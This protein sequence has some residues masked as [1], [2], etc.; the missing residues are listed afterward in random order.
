MAEKNY[1]STDGNGNIILQDINGKNININDV[2]SI[3]KIFENTEPE[4]IQKLFKQ[5]DDNY[6]KFEQENKKQLQKIIAILQ[7]QISERKITVAE[8]KNI[9]T[10]T[11]SNVGGN[12]HI[13]DVIYQTGSKNKSNKN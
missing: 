1:I 10:G 6:Q 4:Y 9:L 8:S 12:V 3:K 13:G 7:Q 2:A 11:I 5:I